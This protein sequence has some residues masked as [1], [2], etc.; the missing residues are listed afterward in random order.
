MNYECVLKDREIIKSIH[1]AI[2]QY[3]N[4]TT[5]GLGSLWFHSNTGLVR[6][7]KL[8]SMIEVK[9][10]F[11]IGRTVWVILW[12]LT[13]SRGNALVNTVIESIYSTGL[14]GNTFY[15]LF[16][17]LKLTMNE[18]KA[19][20]EALKIIARKEMQFDPYKY[21][22]A[23]KLIAMLDDVDTPVISGVIEAI[24]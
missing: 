22:H 18:K 17:N 15:C 21:N 7:Q 4:T 1:L 11:N 19:K 13:M 24:L 6:A 8:R 23:L 20:R 3:L 16:N 5:F 10:V 2:D 14:L 12:A 9:R